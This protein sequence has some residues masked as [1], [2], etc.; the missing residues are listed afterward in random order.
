M[1]LRKIKIDIIDIMIIVAITGIMVSPLYNSGYK[2]IKDY[3]VSS[4]K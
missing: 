3:E 4:K 2:Y 1:N